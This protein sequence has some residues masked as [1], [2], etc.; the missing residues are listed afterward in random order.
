MVTPNTVA[1]WLL[2]VTGFTLA[3]AAW[4]SNRR[5]KLPLPP[6]PPRYWLFG[7]EIPTGSPWLRYE[8]MTQK[9]GPVFSLRRG[10]TD[11]I[12]IGRYEPALE[13][14]EKENAILQDR[15]RSIAVQ[16][17]MCKNMRLLMMG[18]GE[19]FKKF[20]R[21]IQSQLSTRVIQTYQPLQ[22]K[23]AVNLVRD[24]LEDSSQHIEHAKRYAASVV[25]TLTYGKPSTTSYSDPLVQKILLFAHRFGTV[26]RTGAYWVDSMPILQYVPGYLSRLRRWHKEELAFSRSS[27]DTV[28]EQINR[29]E[30][31]IKPN[32][33]QNLL[34][35]KLKNDMSE[36][37]IAFLSGGLFLAGADTTASAISI[38]MMAAAC[39]PDTQSKVQGQLDAV[40][41]R[42][43]A[44][45]FADEAS[46]PFIVAFILECYRWRPV[47]ATG[48]P[49]RA[50]KDII[51]R[52]YRIPAGATVIGSHWSIARSQNVFPE[53]E[54]FCLER[55]LDSSGNIRDDIKSM[56][57]GFGRRVCPGQQ[58]ANRSL[59]ITTAFV[60]WAFRLKEVDGSPI[61]TQ[62]FTQ[63]ANLHPLPFA[64]DFETRIPKEELK[65]I[66]NDYE[67]L[68]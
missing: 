62:A 51:W 55:W 14:M 6:G 40:V 31:I 57:F 33:V 49:H 8:E 10:L 52:G 39:F 50:M 11:I 46:L 66:L 44:P 32:F 22:M 45:T 25:I 65:R 36:D 48:F 21:V 64:L 23:N 17:T 7:T 38:M 37:E 4:Y 29:G 24:L 2:L 26:I 12:I 61:D 1:Y 54:K 27:V 19:R 60:L 30:H 5:S 9:Y 67:A 59:F 56:N 35:K 68:V 20:R 63:T 3:L 42:G 47:S 41:G 16:E 18:A 58:L 28:K 34:E 15:P 53:P 13:I 43:R